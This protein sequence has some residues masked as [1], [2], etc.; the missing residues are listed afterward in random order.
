MGPG[1][2]AAA[3]AHTVVAAVEAGVAGMLVEHIDNAA[4]RVPG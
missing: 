2:K 4:E 3:Q 1:V